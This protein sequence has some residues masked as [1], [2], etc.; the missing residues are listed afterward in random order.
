MTATPGWKITVEHIRIT[1]RKYVIAVREHSHETC[2]VKF[3]K[4]LRWQ[5]GLT[6]SQADTEFSDLREDCPGASF[7][8]VDRTTNTV[9]EIA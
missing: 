4:T 9:Q 2:G 6:K 8:K 3:V 5:T 7:V 1:P